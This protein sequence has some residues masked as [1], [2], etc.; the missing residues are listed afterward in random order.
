MSDAIRILVVDDSA[1]IH[2]FLDKFLGATHPPC[3]LAHV[4]NGQEALERF[5]GG[6][7]PDLVLLDWEMPVLDGPS[8]FGQLRASGVTTPVIMMTTRNDVEDI[9][10]MVTAGVDEYVMKPFTADLIV[11]KISTVL[12]RTLTAHGG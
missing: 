11:D 9:E 3:E 12:G 7:L 2:A 8:T 6:A 4:K 1:T 10:Q 5:A